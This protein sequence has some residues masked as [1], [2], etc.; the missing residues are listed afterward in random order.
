MTGVLARMLVLNWLSVVPAAL[1]QYQQRM[2][3]NN[4]SAT[5]VLTAAGAP[6]QRQSREREDEHVAKDRSGSVV[7]A[8]RSSLRCRS[9]SC[10]GARSNIT[11]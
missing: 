8:R 11:H 7:R 4:V 10:C 3:L 1:R 5:P 9:A 6:E 2:M